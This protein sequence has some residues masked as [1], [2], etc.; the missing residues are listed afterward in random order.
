M[1]SREDIVERAEAYLRQNLAFRV[2]IPRLSRLVGRSERS[3]RNAFYGVHGMGPKR[4]VLAQRLQG[5]RRALRSPAGAST[6]TG[7]ATKY[8]FYELGRF[9]AVY[10]EEFG[11]A[12]SETLRV[13]RRGAG[14]RRG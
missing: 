1:E 6:V 3:L 4:W 8:G 7:I 13:T 2:P 12:P 9:A 14:Q 11:E 10:K 5:V